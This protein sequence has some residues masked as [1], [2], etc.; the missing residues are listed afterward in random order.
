MPT[1]PSYL[2]VIDGRVRVKIQAVKGSPQAADLLAQRLRRDEGVL[3]VHANPVTGNVLVHFD[4]TVTGV[5][6]ILGRLRD[7]GYLNG[8]VAP[9]PVAANGKSP[10]GASVLA[11]PWT[12]TLVQVAAEAAVQSAVRHLITAL[13]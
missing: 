4:P 11:N 3:S 8:H 7:M 6:A 13:L 10:A 9:Q 2:H 1:S 5:E 12:K